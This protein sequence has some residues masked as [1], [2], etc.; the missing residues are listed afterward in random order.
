VE[1]FRKP[2]GRDP[3]AVSDARRHLQTDAKRA[4]HNLTTVNATEAANGAKLPTTNQTEGTAMTTNNDT[5]SAPDHVTVAGHSPSQSPWTAQE[6]ALEFGRFQMLLRQRQLIADGVPVKLGTRAFDLLSVLL[7]A[8]GSLVTKEELLSRVW[9]RLHVSEDNLKVQISTLRQALGEDH[10]FIRTEPGRGYRFTA[11][12]KSTAPRNSSRHAARWQ[13]P[14]R[15]TVSRWMSVRFFP[16]CSHQTASGSAVAKSRWCK[17][18]A[19]AAALGLGTLS[20][21]AQAAPA[22]GSGTVQGLYDTLLNTMKNGRTLG[23]SGRFAQ[24]APVI[25]SS[26]DVA[27]MARLSVGPVWTGLSEGQRQ[28]VTESYG[29]YISAIYADRFD[30]YNGQKLEVTGE[31]P[32]S[33]GLMVKSR[34]IKS[35]GEPVEVDYVMRQNGESWLIA[36]IYLDSAISEVATRRSEFAAILKTQG[37]DGL[38]AALNR[39]ADILTGTTAK[40]S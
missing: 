29:R 2:A 37:I 15:G 31:Q 35:N 26:F 13:R 22:G 33:F 9:P 11:A 38:I 24:L 18:L 32:A 21:T 27:S 4:L 16:E 34:I 14:C 5:E 8:D 39:K 23:G 3:Q 10:D 7:E 30:S 28:E 19:L 1:D 36:D 17:S 20:L 40:S 25:R 6:A 12:I